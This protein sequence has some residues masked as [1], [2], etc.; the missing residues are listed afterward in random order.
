MRQDLFYRL[1]G[2]MIQL[3]ALRERREV[4]PLLVDHFVLLFNRELHKNVRSVTPEVRRVSKSVCK[5]EAAALA[6]VLGEQCAL[7]I[8]RRSAPRIQTGSGYRKPGH[9]R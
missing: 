6:R 2:F 3:P 4:I 1:N 9:R 7:S 5:S 8:V